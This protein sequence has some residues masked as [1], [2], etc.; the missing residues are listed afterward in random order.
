MHEKYAYFLLELLYDIKIHS[1][2]IKALPTEQKKVTKHS[3]GSV[4]LKANL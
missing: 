1:L 3:W 4:S 2:Q